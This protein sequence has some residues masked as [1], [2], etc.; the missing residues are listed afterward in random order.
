MKNPARQKALPF[1]FRRRFVYDSG[2]S[3][4]NGQIRLITL[5]PG[6]DPGIVKCRLHTVN[7]SD[8]PV[9]E[10]LSY[11]WVD[12]WGQNTILLNGKRFDIRYNL[13]QALKH[14]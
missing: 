3:L 7:L 4:T 14:L 12:E 10:A 11:Q 6:R 9:Y 2:L 8:K 13:L 1:M 5:L